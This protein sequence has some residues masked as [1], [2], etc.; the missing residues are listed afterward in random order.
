MQMNMQSTPW[1]HEER[2]YTK[3]ATDYLKE[4]IPKLCVTKN[5]T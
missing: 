4:K 5:S 3:F 1:F 2:D